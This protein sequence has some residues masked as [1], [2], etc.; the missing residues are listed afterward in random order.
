M[1]EMT[2]C[3]ASQHNNGNG[4]AL[5]LQYLMINFFQGFTLPSFP[6]FVYQSSKVNFFRFEHFKSVRGQRSNTATFDL[7]KKLG[8]HFYRT[9][10]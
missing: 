5:N 10:N 9:S 2:S 7:E 1:K 6:S 4:T 3:D 8:T